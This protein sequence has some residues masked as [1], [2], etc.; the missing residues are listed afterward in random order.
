MAQ[1]ASALPASP[2]RSSASKVLG[3][4]VW[5][6][7][8]VLAVGFVLKYV[9]HYYLNYNQ[10]A[11]EPYWS[12]R[13]ALLMH[14]TGGMVALLTAP[15]QF[16]TG[17]RGKSMNVHRVTGLVFVSAVAVGSIGGFWLAF[18]TTFGW[19][20]GVGAAG[21]ALAWSVTTG[22]AWYAIRKGMTQ[23]HKEWMIRA[24]VVTFA[25]VTFRV[26]NDY[27]P[28]SHLQP[29]SDRANMLI[30]GCWAVPLLITEVVLQLRR[31]PGRRA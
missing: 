14:I 21:L 30:W 26:F 16:F 1:A 20:W 24:Y 3:Y 8:V 27:G 6:G 15:W 28:L 23:V 19:A 7:L 17:L 4:L 2:G 22:M 5:A 11:F 9:F 29:A 12:R 25:F 10:Q 13:P 18:T 31:L